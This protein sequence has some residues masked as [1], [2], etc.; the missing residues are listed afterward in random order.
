VDSPSAMFL[1]ELSLYR[2]QLEPGSRPG[3]NAEPRARASKL[4]VVFLPLS[5]GSSVSR[6][7]HPPPFSRS[8]RLLLLLS[9][10]TPYSIHIYDVLGL[11]TYL[12]NSACAFRYRR[13]HTNDLG[14]TLNASYHENHDYDPYH[15]PPRTLRTPRH[16]DILPLRRVLR[17]NVFQWI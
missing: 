6:F 9:E 5:E 11:P 15:C 10:Q 4:V 14:T 12:R 3:P 2:D 16:R 7:R 1:C 17:R 8:L 13:G